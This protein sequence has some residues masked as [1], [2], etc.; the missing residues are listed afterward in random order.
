[1][2]ERTKLTEKDRRFVE[3][4]AYVQIAGL[5]ICSSAVPLAMSSLERIALGTLAIG[6]GTSAGVYFARRTNPYIKDIIKRY[7]EEEK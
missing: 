1:M 6:V 4:L 5:G 2:T 3:R 7:L